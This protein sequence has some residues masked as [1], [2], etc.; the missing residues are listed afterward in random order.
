MRIRTFSMTLVLALLTWFAGPARGEQY[1][2]PPPRD[3][4]MVKAIL[5]QAPRASTERPLNIVLLAGTKDHEVNEHDYPL[6]QKRWKVLLGGVRP[7]DE[8]VVNLY[9]PAA[10][11]DKQDLAGAEN[12]RVS[13][14]WDWPSAEQW[15]TADLVVMFSFPS[16]NDERLAQLETYLNRGGGFVIIHMPVWYPSPKLLAMVGGAF[17]NQAQ[18]RHG[19]V[20]LRLGN[21]KHPI[22]LGLSDE[23]DTVDESY[24]NLRGEPAKEDVLATCRETRTSESTPRDEPMFWTHRYGKGRV[25]VCILGHFTWTF[26]DPLVRILLL[27]G[28]AWAAGE[29]PYRFDPLVL[30]GARV[31]GGKAAGPDAAA[32]DAAVAALADYDWG[33]SRL[34]L[35]P[36]DE[37]VRYGGPDAVTD[38][39]KRLAAALGKKLSPAASDFVCRRLALIGTARSVPALAALLPDKKR[40][41]M[42]RYAIEQIPDDAAGAALLASLSSTAGPARIEVIRSL[43]RRGYRPATETLLA[44][45]RGDDRQDADAALAALA[46]MGVPEAVEP[47]LARPDAPVDALLTLAERLATDGHKELSRKIYNRLA[48]SS[49]PQV[50]SAVLAGLVRLEE[51]Y[52]AARRLLAALAG[53]DARMRSQAVALVA[54]SCGEPCVAAVVERFGVLPAAAQQALLVAPW[55]RHPALGRQCALRAVTSENPDIRRDALGLLRY[56]G[57]AEDVGWLATMAGDDSAEVAEAAGLALKYLAADGTNLVIVE[58]LGKYEGA[59]RIALIAAARERQVSEAVPVLIKLTQATDAK[60][61][62]AALGAIETLGDPST[63]PALVTRLLAAQTPQERAAAERAVW[64]CARRA[65]DSEKRAESLLQAIEGAPPADRAVLLPVLGR[66]GGRRALEAVRQ[67]EKSSDAAERDA[68]ARALSNWPDATVADDLLELARGGEKPSQ[69]IAALRG[70]IRVVTL[71]GVRSDRETLA[72]LRPA[73]ELATRVEEKRLI[74]SRLS[75]IV[76]PESLEL[77]V[78]YLDQPEVRGEAIAASTRLAELLLPK[79][80]EAAKAAMKKILAVAT[81]KKLRARLERQLKK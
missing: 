36:I 75:A 44:I 42:A 60:T 52:S 17:R 61:R 24:F 59:E 30:R 23:I 57:R 73:I 14:A 26:D 58:L 71:R 54:H 68:A 69:R 80:P 39:E 35:G 67:A 28:M 32:I 10:P 21:A 1:T 51:P 40:A 34:A 29:S 78:S 64:L 18:Y 16:W 41:A 45:L 3:A 65:K 9:G 50:Q 81:D 5:A 20:T 33:K 48:K 2:P 37:V 72:M 38:L 70:Y 12:V 53:G 27:R 49:L 66:L 63:A 79:H 6:W 62:I 19:P 43:G 47:A 77:A 56:V 4:K 8:P 74:L 22:C 11:L 15:K 25:M 13:T 55:T 76:V 46:A 31:T 7:G